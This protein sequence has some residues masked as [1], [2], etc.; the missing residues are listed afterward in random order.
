MA[1]GPSKEE[2]EIYWKQSRQYFDELASYYRTADPQYYNDYIAP[3]YNNPFTNIQGRKGS[4]S[5]LPVVFASIALLIT[6]LIAGAVF[7]I[8]QVKEEK[9]IQK[10]SPKIEKQIEK[11]EKNSKADTIST[12]E[13]TPRKDRNR[14]QPI[15]RYR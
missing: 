9:T 12:E 7:F 13:K 1:S 11:D 2:L 5:P 6:G 10:E 3:F 4:S 14:K 15:E 8:L